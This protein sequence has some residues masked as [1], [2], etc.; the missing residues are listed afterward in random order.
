MSIIFA[1]TVLFAATVMNANADSLPFYDPPSP[2]IPSYSYAF[3][4]ASSILREQ[5]E[6]LLLRNGESP[7]YGATHVIAFVS[8]DFKNIRDELSG[9]VRERWGILE[10]YENDTGQ[11][12]EPPPQL[13]R[14][15]LSWP[16][17]GEE[18]CR[19]RDNQVP[20]KT[21]EYQLI[22]RGYNDV[23]SINGRSQVVIRISDGRELFGAEVAILQITRSDRSR[24]WA[25][26]SFH[27]LI[28]LPYKEERLSV[29][30][31][32]STEIALIEEIKSKFP[33]IMVR[34]F[35][36]Q[37]FQFH[38]EDGRLL[39]LQMEQALQQLKK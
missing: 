32:T 2:W 33:G 30:V 38:P 26:S 21:R 8:R 37:S 3:K 34:Y 39:R 11:I 24:E 31:V 27:G 7:V 29:G 13:V 19:L 18:L 15:D 6:K 20:I 23:P 36:T 22:S 10:E 28:P 25:R 12:P 9:L 1:S 4:G 16:I 35:V 14:A 5:G 17:L